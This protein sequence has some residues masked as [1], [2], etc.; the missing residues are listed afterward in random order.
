MKLAW[1][2]A[3]FIVQTLGGRYP[4][5]AYKAQTIDGDAAEW[6]K[7]QAEKHGVVPDLS[8]GRYN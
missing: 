4:K 1:L 5:K 8:W 3:I 7:T 2:F 6:C